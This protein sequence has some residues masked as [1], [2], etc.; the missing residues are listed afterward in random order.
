MENLKKHFPQTTNDIYQKLCENLRAK[1][2]SYKFFSNLEANALTPNIKT[3][4][5]NIYYEPKDIRVKTRFTPDDFCGIRIIDMIQNG[6]ETVYSRDDDTFDFLSVVNFY[7]D[8]VNANKE[9]IKAFNKDIKK[10]GV[11]YSFTDVKNAIETPNCE[12]KETLAFILFIAY[13]HKYNLIYRSKKMYK[14]IV[15]DTNEFAK[16]HILE[17][18]EISYELQYTPRHFQS[19]I[20]NTNAIEMYK[21]DYSFYPITKISLK[22]IVKIIEVLGIPRLKKTK[23]DL[24]NEIIEYI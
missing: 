13:I 14:H 23:S 18:T 6:R 17:E 22:D 5:R 21:L 9:K 8:I 20:E 24:Y 11:Q 12:K 19:Y 3:R 4:I 10:Y 2:P 1:S 16:S 15:N 7:K